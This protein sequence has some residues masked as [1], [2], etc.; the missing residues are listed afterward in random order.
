MFL[1]NESEEAKSEPI[2]NKIAS[3]PEMD[4]T[5]FMELHKAIYW[6]ICQC[7]FEEQQKKMLRNILVVGGGFAL[8][9]GALAFLR[10][11]LEEIVPPTLEMCLVS[12][13]REVPADLHA[14]KGGSIMGALET[15]QYLWIT[16]QVKNTEIGLLIPLS[17]FVLLDVSLITFCFF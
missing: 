14:F 17:A 11:K 5:K 1:Q 16:K 12:N 13:S 15:V 9:P 4:K 3:R 8:F 2:S 10:M 6:S 7:P